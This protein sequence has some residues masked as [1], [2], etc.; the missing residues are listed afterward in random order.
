MTNSMYPPFH[1]FA[2]LWP[3]PAV[4]PG[5]DLKPENLVFDERGHLKAR[6]TR[7]HM[8]Y[9]VVSRRAAPHRLRLLPRGIISRH[10]TLC[11]VV[12]FCHA[13]IQSMFNF[14]WHYSYITIMLY[15]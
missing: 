10:T 7:S 1:P 11:Y 5:R 8:S 4:S 14:V 12:H 13:A 9:H 15:A 6:Q 2:S 3:F